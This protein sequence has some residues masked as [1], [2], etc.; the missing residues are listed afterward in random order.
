MQE[1]FRVSIGIVLFDTWIHMISE[2][3]ICHLVKIV[4][5][6]IVILYNLY[7]HIISDYIFCY[8]HY[9]EIWCVLLM[10]DKVEK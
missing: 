9:T 5:I 8:F 2:L 3:V 10:I 1:W 4:S 6:G 7:I